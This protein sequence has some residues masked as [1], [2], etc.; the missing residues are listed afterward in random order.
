MEAPVAITFADDNVKALCLAN[1]DNNND[2]KLSMDEAAAVTDLGT[3]F[4]SNS[5]ITSF[6]EL[7]YFTGLTAIRSN[8]FYNCSGLTS[9]T[10]PESVDSIGPYAFS[11]CS[12]LTSTTIPE[13]V[14]KIGR[15]A[16]Y[17]CTGLTSVHISNLAA[18][19]NIK[20]YEDT[21]TSSHYTNPLLYAHHLLINNEEIKDL[22]IPDGVTKIGDYTF[23]GCTGL[24]SVTIPESVTS[25]GAFAFRGC[26]GL[27]SF[28][29]PESVTSICTYAFYDANNLQRV[30]ISDLESWCNIDF[31]SYYSNPLAK[32]HYLYLNGNRIDDLVIP[33]NV[34]MIKG[35]CFNGGYFSSVSIPNTTYSIERNAFYVANIGEITTKQTIGSSAFYAA[36]IDHLVID[37]SVNSVDDLAFYNV[38]INKLEIPYSERDL[39]W[40][41][42]RNSDGM[43]EWATIGTAIVDRRILPRWEG[44][45]IESTFK[46][47]TIEELRIGPHFI[48]WS[49]DFFSC[50]I[51]DLYFDG[52]TEIRPNAFYIYS[53]S[54]GYNSISNVYLPQGLTSIGSDAF[55]YCGIKSVIIENESPLEISENTF[56]K[57]S[58]ATLFVP[59]GCKS[60]Y[61]G[62]DYWKEFRNIIEK[63]GTE[64]II[65]FAD[66]NTKAVCVGKWDKNGDGELSNLEVCTVVD[67]SND[68]DNNE[69]IILFDEFRYFTG[70]SYLTSSYFYYCSNL[71]SITIPK[72][73]LSVDGNLFRGCSNLTNLSVD[74]ENTVYDSRNNCNA[75]IETSSNTLITGCKNTTIPNSVT[76]IGP[77]AFYSCEL[78]TSVTIP[79]GVTSIGNYAFFDCSSLT[80]VTVEWH[81][82]LAVPENIFEDVDLVNATLYIPAGTSA[83]YKAAD[84]WKDFGKIVEHTDLVENGNMEEEP[85]ADWSSFWVHE[86]RTMEEQFEGPA[87]IVA[88]PSDA[89]NHCVK[90]VARSE[91]EAREAGN[92]TEDGDGNFALWDS[93]FFIQSKV[94]IESGKRLRLKMRVKADK[95]TEIITEAHQAPGDYNYW[96]VFDNINVTDTWQTVER[97]VVITPDMTQEENGREMRTVAFHLTTLPEGNNFYFDDIKLEVLVQPGII[98]FI[99]NNVKALCVTNWDTNHDGELSMA[100]AAAVTELGEVFKGNEEI[101][102]FNELQYFTGLTSISEH[103]FND[104]HGLQSVIIPDNVTSIG[105][106]A[107]SGCDRLQTVNI[108]N[109]V[110]SIGK[111][112]FNVCLSLKNITIP[113]TVNS[114]GEYAFGTVNPTSITVEW[115]EPL[116]VPENIFEDINYNNVILYV[117]EGTKAAYKTADVWKDFWYIFESENL[118]E[119]GS[120]EGEQP[121]DWSYFWVREWRNPESLFVGPANIVEDPINDDNHCIKVVARSEEEALAAGNATMN[122]DHLASWDTEFFIHVKQSIKSGDKLRLTMRVRADKPASVKTEAQSAPTEYNHDECFGIINFTK[123]WS[124]VVKEVIVTPEMTQEENGREMHAITFHLADFREGNVYYFDD[125]KL[126]MITMDKYDAERLLRELIVNMEAIGGYELDD[127]K[128]IANGVDV[129]K[130]DI[131]DAIAQLQQQ[132]KDRCANAGSNDQPV[133]ATGLITNPSFTFDNATYWQGDTPQFERF[134]NAEFYE[135]TFDFYQELTDLPNGNYLLKVKGFHRPGTNGDVY[136]DYRQGTDNASALLYANDG[137]VTLNNQAAF[138][139]D[140]Q[141]DGWSGVEVSHDGT[142][143]YVPNSMADAYMWFNNGYYENELPVTV[144]D[145]TL[146]LGI[147][148]EESVAY[149]WVIFDDFRLEYLGKQVTEGNR[150]YVDESEEPVTI[151][152]GKTATVSLNLDNEDEMIA[153]QFSMKLPD[154]ISIKKDKAG[155]FECFLNSERCDGHEIRVRQDDNGYYH[156]ICNHEDNNPFTG[157]TGELLNFRLICD[158]EAETGFC[159]AQVYNIVFTNENRKSIFMTDLAIDF[160]VDHLLVGDVNNDGFVNVTDLAVMVDYMMGVEMNVEEFN[161]DASDH[162]NDNKIN[163][164][165]LVKQVDIIFEAMNSSPG[166]NT[167]T[168]IDNGLSLNTGSDGSVHLR[169]ADNARFI[170]S[171][172]TVTLSDG[173]ILAG[174]TTDNGHDTHVQQLSPNRYS[175]IS[176]SMDNTPYSS[177]DHTMTLH[178]AGKGSVTVEEPIFTDTRKNTVTFHDVNTDTTGMMEAESLTV[179]TD[180][181]STNGVMVKKDATSIK[182]LRSGVYIVKG[183]KYSKK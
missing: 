35:F 2:G 136:N 180:I 130:D 12:G 34:G 44:S 25:I 51:T 66:A 17:N 178:V 52:I 58:Y 57:R 53:T 98:E 18:W 163:V 183:R 68:F 115:Q 65:N 55:R 112:A 126:E 118:V 6:D 170:A 13:S 31:S 153:F 86:W 77:R 94:K 181:Y 76:S 50:T 32:A 40:E 135:T 45:H 133:D 56:E 117:P 48:Y 119:N 175:V 121:E 173:Q 164:M 81:E 152:Q 134:N 155:M 177:A 169:V 103:A 83:A 100:E 124:Q 174:V 154:G 70:L 64:E 105:Q 23:E 166:A 1:W 141:I 149:G 110:T 182:G 22:I 95:A 43:F 160:D 62:A 172:F 113:S 78:L 61:E 54:S 29:I 143:Q 93:Q 26:S 104:C 162:N 60:T 131:E 114:I 147:R 132:I 128:A 122:G 10:I 137:G 20:F 14:T 168:I 71:Q 145:G 85:S 116:A 28:T 146:R 138:A 33:D 109:G 107:F 19:C 97:E 179:P 96:A 90:V 49:Q 165:D 36:T 7:Q 157:D 158:K 129:T 46:N 91:A 84:V 123:Q 37:P 16:F 161:F 142:L 63:P 140:E 74:E 159:Q 42:G 144:T 15:N 73:V 87:N 47:T 5:T 139:L 3:V 11:C 67:A 156:F 38:K 120:L 101:T 9:V 125:I 88:D 151:H 30:N 171:Q 106:E 92:M 111:W 176:Y 72:S 102:R 148:L 127:A 79:S 4:E 69:D 41:S 21:E 24:T 167:S 8:A 39:I 75:I 108:P 99:D 150:L 59:F 89:G 82:P 27:T 80:S